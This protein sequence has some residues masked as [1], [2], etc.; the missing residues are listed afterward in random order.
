VTVPGEG[1]EDVRADEQ[2]DG[3]HVC[4]LNLRTKD[5]SKMRMR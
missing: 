3:P 4:V 1:H 2:K 5:A